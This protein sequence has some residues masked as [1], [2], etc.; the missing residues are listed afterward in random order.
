M[1]RK[2]CAQFPKYYVLVSALA[3]GL[4]SVLRFIVGCLPVYMAYALFGTLMFGKISV[5][6]ASIRRSLITLFSLLNGDSMLEI[7]DS[8]YVSGWAGLVSE[9]YLISF[10]CLFIY[11]AL[12]IF[13]QIMQSAFDH[14]QVKWHQRAQSCAQ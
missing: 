8:I 11:S 14:T 9:V 1:S 7:F 5:H 2:I 4:P 6:F 12:N 10:V 13:I 3:Q